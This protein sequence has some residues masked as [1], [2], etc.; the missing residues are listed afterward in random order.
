MF[1]SVSD[2]TLDM[3]VHVLCRKINESSMHVF[4]Q[5][6]ESEEYLERAHSYTGRT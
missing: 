3:K 1:L 5:W 2:D 4:E 6:E